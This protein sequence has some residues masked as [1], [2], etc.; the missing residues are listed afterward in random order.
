MV[1]TTLAE[2]ESEMLKDSNLVRG[3]SSLYS[4]EVDFVGCDECN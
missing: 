4:H 2:L 1:K 3:A